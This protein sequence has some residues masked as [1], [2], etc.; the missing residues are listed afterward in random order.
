MHAASD[1]SDMPA[2]NKPQLAKNPWNTFVCSQK[3]P[4]RHARNRPGRICIESCFTGWTPTCTN[5]ASARSSAVA[6]QTRV[7]R[8][9][10][11][12]VQCFHPFGKSI[13]IQVRIGA[14]QMV[15]GR[16]PGIADA[17]KDMIWP[18]VHKQDLN[19]TTWVPSWLARISSAGTIWACQFYSACKN[20][21]FTGQLKGFKTEYI[22]AASWVSH[23]SYYISRSRRSELREVFYCW[24]CSDNRSEAYLKQ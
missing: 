6:W 21:I 19:L 1:L 8:L 10:S 7:E 13:Q 4:F 11:H 3:L 16:A 15:P 20:L 24:S 17:W 14:M 23:H 9:Q 5:V 22:W 2:A 12:Q 18:W